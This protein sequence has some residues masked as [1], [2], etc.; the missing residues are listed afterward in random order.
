MEEFIQKIIENHKELEYMKQGIRDGSNVPIFSRK[1]R[2]ETMGERNYKRRENKMLSP[3][4]KCSYQGLMR[5]MLQ[6]HTP[7]HELFIV[8]SS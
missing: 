4:K 5:I 7:R 3:K 6:R 8:E 1:K 2:I